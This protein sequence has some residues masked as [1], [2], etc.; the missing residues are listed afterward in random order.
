MGP[1]S[2]TCRLH[3]LHAHEQSRT[4]NLYEQSSSAGTAH[5]SVDSLHEHARNTPRRQLA[6]RPTLGLLSYSQTTTYDSV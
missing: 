5:Y 4:C 2:V 3:D 6:S 1:L